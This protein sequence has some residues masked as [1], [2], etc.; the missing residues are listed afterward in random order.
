MKN[1]KLTF[2]LTF[3][4]IGSIAQQKWRQIPTIREVEYVS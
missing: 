3:P 4:S 1:E 2:T